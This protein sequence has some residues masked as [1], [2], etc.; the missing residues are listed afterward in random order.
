MYGC[1]KVKGFKRTQ[2]GAKINSFVKFNLQFFTDQSNTI[3]QYKEKILNF[4][5]KI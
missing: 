4:F 3:V 2:S 5:N 1:K